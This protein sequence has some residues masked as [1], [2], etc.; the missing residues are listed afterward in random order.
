MGRLDERELG[1]IRWLLG[2]LLV[3]ISFAGS[4]TINLGAD[5][6]LTTGILV[7]ALS[8]FIPHWLEQLSPAVW[9]VATVLLILAIAGDFLTSGGDLLPP[10]FRMVALLTLFRALQ[11]RTPRE[12]LQILLLALFLLL[13]TG[14]LSQ[15]VYFALQIL[16]F[17]PIA[18]ALLFTVT[19]ATADPEAAERTRTLRVFRDL[20]WGRLL[21]HVRMRVDRHTLA[22]GVWLF[23]TMSAMTFLLFFFMP[24]FDIGAALPFPRLK[25][26]QSL[27]GF[28][29][30]V[31]YGDVVD[32]L[33]DDSIAMRVDVDTDDPPARP[34]WRMVVLDAYYDGGFM[35]SPRVARER[36]SFNNFAFP[37]RNFADPEAAEDRTWTLYLE[38]GISGYLPTGDAFQSFRFNDRQMVQLHDLTRVFSMPEIN[39]NTLSIRFEGL[40]FAGRVNQ[41]YADAGLALMPP[42]YVDTAEAAYLREVAYPQTTLAVPEGPANRRILDRLVGQVGPVEDLGAREFARRMVAVL[43]SGRGYSLETRI[44]EGEADRLLRWLDTPAPGHCELYAGSFVLLARH[45]GFPARLVTGFAGGDWNGFENYFMVRNRHAHAWVELFDPE[46][47]WI[48]VDPTPGAGGEEES[49]ARAIADGELFADRT[50]QA[51]LDSLRVLWFRRVIQ[52][53]SEDQEVMAEAVKEVGMGGLAWMRRHLKSWMDGVRRD[54]RILFDSG[55]WGN[56]PRDFFLPTVLL[57]FSIGSLYW[58]RKT[59]LQRTF[60]PV[61]RRRAGRLLQ[62]EING[63]G[64][65]SP[66]VREVLRTIRYGPRGQWPQEVARYLR[67]VQRRRL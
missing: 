61:M 62:A 24:R 41:T 3:L 60:V 16:V 39:A 18:M 54:A 50:W 31:R 37:F 15:D 9:K 45:A 67:Q 12:D 51:Y 32:I 42:V 66:D 47:G 26:S 10:L 14:V 34:Y 64:P 25:T 4:Y 43:R 33:D 29:D 49:V 44:P 57:L 6:L 27:T 56:L 30:H 52:F 38:G 11:I 5:L 35:V 19:L 2:Q 13:I 55:D 7:V 21:R 28:T 8:L 1:A 65:W 40:S 23:L 48:R 63:S 20:Q 46:E 17:A 58:L 53:D 59:R 22:A 36:R